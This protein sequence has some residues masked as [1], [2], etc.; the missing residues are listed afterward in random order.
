MTICI[1][2]QV[3]ILMESNNTSLGQALV[4]FALII[5]LFLIS[6]RIEHVVNI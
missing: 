3:N 2:Y 4:G 1:T 6:A 5:I